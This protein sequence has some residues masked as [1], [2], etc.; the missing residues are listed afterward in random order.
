MSTKM[1]GGRARALGLGLLIASVPVLGVLASCGSEP[2]K[3]KAV[4]YEGGAGGEAGMGAEARGGEGGQLADAGA[5]QGGAAGAQEPVG[6][7]GGAGGAGDGGGAGGAPVGCTPPVGVG[8]VRGGPIVE[9]ETWTAAESPHFVRFDTGLHATVTIEPCAT[10]LIAPSRIITVFSD[11]GIVAEGTADSPIAIDAE[12][13]G[14]PWGS[15]QVGGG[16][17]VRFAYAT[18]AGGGEPGNTLVDYA[19]VLNVAADVQSPA[20]PVLHLDHVTIS[21]SASQGVYLHNG[22]GFTPESTELSI[23]GSQGA[24]LHAWTSAAGGIPVGDY[25]G[26]A[27]DV[28]ILSALGCGNEG[29]SSGTVTLRDLG[30]PYHVGHFG[31]AGNLCVGSGDGTTAT[32]VIEP[33]VELRFKAGGF[34]MVHQFGPPEPTGGA[35]VAQGTLAK[36]ILFTSAEPTP[37]AGDWLGLWLTKKAHPTTIIDHARVEYAGGVTITGSSSC[38]FGDPQNNA[39][40]RIF[41]EPASQFVTN[42]TIAFSATNGID[43]GYVGA[44][45]DFLA[46]NKFQNIAKCAQT[47]PN[48]SPC[49]ATVPCP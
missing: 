29:V 32:L 26:N 47:Y 25:T 43:R 49:P 33:G 6:S 44:P 5:A 27:R 24:A 35:L 13:E 11:G 22:G 37:S 34:L 4:A 38:N 45:V 1:M 2:G 7:I 3:K 12:Q 40:I 31:S 30:V 15:I 20:Q 41:T 21:D 36:P 16:G 18:L 14:M 8:T 48:T 42:T 28:I 17:T 23:V 46:T 10:V 9:D 19:G 39:A